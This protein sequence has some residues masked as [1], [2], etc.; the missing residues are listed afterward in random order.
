MKTTRIRRTRSRTISRKESAFFQKKDNNENTFFPVAKQNSFFPAVNRKCDSCNEEDKKAQRKEANQEEPQPAKSAEEKVPIEIKDSGSKLPPDVR[1]DYEAKTGADLSAVRIHTGSDAERMAKSVNAQAFTIGNDIVFDKGKYQPDSD[2]GRKLLAHELAHI[3]QQ[4]SKVSRVINRSPST[5]FE[6]SGIFPGAASFP[7]AIFFD[8]GSALIPSSEKGK[9]PAIASKFTGKNITLTGTAS[10]EGDPALNLSIINS[11]IRSVDSSV[12]IAGHTGTRSRNPQPGVTSGTMDYRR[13]RSV[14]VIETPS[15]VPP[16]GLPPTTTPPCAVTPA[17]PHPEDEPCGVSFLT[18]YPLSLLWTATANSQLSSA[19]PLAV[20]ET[21]NLFPGI[22]I[23]TVSANVSSLLTQLGRL[24]AQHQCHN[25]CDGG[26]SR[27]A[28]NRGTGSSSMMTLCPDFITNTNTNNRAETLIHESLHAT[29]GLATV[30]TAYLTTRL[31]ISLTGPQALLNT[32]SYVLLILRLA[33]ITPTSAPPTDT[34]VGMTAAEEKFALSALAFLEQWL[35]NAEFD[36]SLVYNAINKNIG[37]VGGWDT[38][39]DFE[40][41][42]MHLIFNLF[43]LTDPGSAS[44]FS[45]TPVDSDKFKMAGMFDRYTRMRQSVY[46]VPITINK[47]TSG[48][49]FWAPNLGNIVKVASSFFTLSSLDSVKR[50]L[51]LMLKSMSDVP[52]SKV[53]SY[54][55]GANHIRS[56]RGTGP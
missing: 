1:K 50:L 16:T 41:E 27:P 47:I 48:A 13:V 12:R 23:A 56:H 33:G 24:A 37:R 51:T 36:T 32:D 11:R 19:T 22:P 14:E 28:F 21:G 18:A 15:V 9:I 5:G 40:A 6:I 45:T 42:I 31:I 2:E 49:E 7:D 55:E 34:F 43:G 44:P 20:T 30:D 3:I 38:A 25:F 17:T 8:R 54:M 52:S 53:N 35:L 26:C 4:G 46:T 29:P 39:D 10:E